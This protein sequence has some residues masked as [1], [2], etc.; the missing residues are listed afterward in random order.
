MYSTTLNRI[1]IWKKLDNTYYYRII[2]GHYSDYFVGYQ[3][4]YG[5]EVVLIIDNLEYR[6]KKIPRK[7]RLKKQLINLIEKI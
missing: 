6:I 5:H 1:I 7:V 3:N 2:K 4:S